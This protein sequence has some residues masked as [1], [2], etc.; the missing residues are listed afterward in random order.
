MCGEKFYTQAL[1]SANNGL[2]IFPQK[3]FQTGKADWLTAEKVCGN[4]GENTHNSDI[5][6]TMHATGHFDNQHNAGDRGADD[7]GKQSCHAEHDK[8]E[9]Q[10]RTDREN[11]DYNVAE[12]GAGVG[13]ENK[14]RKENTAGNFRARA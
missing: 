2:F 10:I 6:K 5:Q 8:L 11:T 13:A 14:Q 1:I 9:T 3:A 4:A 12:Y 7:S